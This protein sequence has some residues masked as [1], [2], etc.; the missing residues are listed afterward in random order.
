MKNALVLGLYRAPPIISKGTILSGL[1]SGVL[2]ATVFLGFNGHP[3]ADRKAS[4]SPDENLVQIEM[5]TLPPEPP[6]T[7][8]ADDPP[9]DEAPQV[10]YAPPSLVDIPTVT[11]DATFVQ[12]VSPPPPPG[13]EQA[14]GLV[15]IPETR[16]AGVGQGVNHIFD[17]AQL[18]QAPE[19]RVQQPPIYPASL[20]RS[21]R[22]GEVS[23]EFI[24]DANGNVL[25]PYVI[26]AS[27][28]DLAGPAL[29]AIRRWK[30]RPGRRN[31]RNVST[32]MSEAI[33][34][35]LD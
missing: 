32:R 9:E 22:A 3:N 14:K 33:A 15:T 25:D 35:Q 24:V 6:D 7:S 18:D 19:V 16:P 30:F 12:T 5:P 23:V 4:A 34:F 27:D 8:K 11:P 13:I 21:G 28:E 17:L 26:N 10:T 31:G 29:Q 1:L 2:L 20:R